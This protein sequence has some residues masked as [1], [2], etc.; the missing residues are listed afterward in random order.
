MREL[1]LTF[2]V[3]DFISENSTQALKFMIEKLDAYGLRGLFFITGHMAEKLRAHPEIVK[4][5]GNHQIGYTPPLIPL[6]LLF[7]ILLTSHHTK[8][9]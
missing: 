1:F 2:D 5:L 3:E 9:P 7:S 4:L 8:Q 6:S